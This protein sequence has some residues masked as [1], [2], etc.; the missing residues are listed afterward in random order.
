MI[1]VSC[2]KLGYEKF[3]LCLTVRVRTL[4]KEG[5]KIKFSNI[6][7]GNLLEG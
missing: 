4:S 2:I 3:T 6:L 5:K 1:L 7:E